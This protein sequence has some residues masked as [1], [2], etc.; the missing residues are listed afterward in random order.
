MTPTLCARWYAHGDFS[1]C[2]IDTRSKVLRQRGASK[3]VISI[4]AGKTIPTGWGCHD[5]KDRLALFQSSRSLPSWQPQP[6]GMVLPAVMEITHLLAP[7][8][9]N[10]F[11]RVSIKH[12]EKSPC[13]YHQCTQRG[14]HVVTLSLREQVSIPCFRSSERREGRRHVMRGTAMTNLLT[15]V[16]SAEGVLLSTV[17]HRLSVCRERAPHTG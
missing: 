3:C 12:T 10:T 5:G 7:R 4:T 13:A 15:D 6:V 16:A 2:L 9:R 14:R 1:V 8:W 17:L 11:E